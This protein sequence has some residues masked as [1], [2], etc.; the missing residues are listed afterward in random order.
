MYLADYHIH[1]HHS[2]DS[3]AEMEKI[4][5][6]ALERGMDEIALTDHLDFAAGKSFYEIL[7]CEKWY[8]ELLSVKEKYAG[9]LIVKLGIE[10]GT[11]QYNPKEFAS[12]HQKYPLDF[13]IGSVHNMPDHTDIG[14]YSFYKIDYKRI[15]EKYHML[16]MEL[17]KNYEYD[18]L[19]H[20]TYPSRYIEKQLGIDVD[21]HA[22]TDFYTALFQVLIERG[23]GIEMNTSGIARG[24][25]TIM[26]PLWL[27]RFYRE[28]G[29]EIITI[30]TDSHVADQVGTT[31]E[32]ARTLLKEAGFR[33]YAVYTNHHFD[34][35]KI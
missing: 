7:D 20:L 2:F 5:E 9:K 22:Y 24:G 10:V 19:G 15:Y 29:G 3:E 35:K 16:L 33:Y 28:C 14:D 26:P 12:F 32:L 34:M 30:G 21:V 18:V 11:P 13:I 27:I 17:A 25:R 23:K 31:V 8:A 1:T 6:N 4:C